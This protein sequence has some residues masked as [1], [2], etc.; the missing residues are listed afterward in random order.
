MTNGKKWLRQCNIVMFI[1]ANSNMA[2][3]VGH[4]HNLHFFVIPRT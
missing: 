4:L 3:Q 1:F 2:W